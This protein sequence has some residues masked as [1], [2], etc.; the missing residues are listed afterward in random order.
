MN[1]RRRAEHDMSE[2]RHLLIV[3]IE[4]H[5]AYESRIFDF[6]PSHMRPDILLVVVPLSGEISRLDDAS[7]VASL[8]IWLDLR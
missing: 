1:T 8:P 4:N 6:N 7:C 3:F 2:D 5:K